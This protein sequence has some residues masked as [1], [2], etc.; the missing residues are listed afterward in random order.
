MADSPISKDQLH[1]VASHIQS[2]EQLEILCLLVANPSKSWLASEIFRHIQSTEKSVEECLQYFLTRGLLSVDA[3][4]LFQ[5]SP[6]TPELAQSAID[7]VKT[8]REC[9]VTVIE[10][11]YKKPRDPVQSFA[12]AFRLRKDK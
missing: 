11:I 7:L 9:R 6:K 1:F 3:H 4:C 12:E 8:Y 10:A 2:V 5:F